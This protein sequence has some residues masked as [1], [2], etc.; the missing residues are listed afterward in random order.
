M[1]AFET[2]F[3]ILNPALEERELV[4]L[5]LS[6]PRRKSDELRRLIIKP[7]MLKAGF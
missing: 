4:R 3:T 6:K 1:S 7:V 5:T 2:F